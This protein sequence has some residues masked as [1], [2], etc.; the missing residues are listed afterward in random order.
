[1][2]TR[3][4]FLYWLRRQS[5]FVDLKIDDKRFNNIHERMYV[6]SVIDRMSSESSPFKEHLQDYQLL[7][8][9]RYRILYNHRAS[10]DESVH[11]IG[12]AIKFCSASST[13]QY[14][15]KFRINPEL[16][17]YLI[18]SRFL[19]DFEGNINTQEQEHY[20]FCIPSFIPNLPPKEISTLG[21]PSILLDLMSYDEVFSFEEFLNL[22]E[23]NM[24]TANLNLRAFLIQFLKEQLLYYQSILLVE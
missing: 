1:M 21:F 12:K 16:K 13:Q 2:K 9:Q 3:K 5:E 23:A 7:E 17:D 22:I 18:K 14:Q 19:W 4:S 15:S 20:Y 8:E 24:D 11:Q 10:N 6:F